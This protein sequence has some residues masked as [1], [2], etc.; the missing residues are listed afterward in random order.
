MRAT[1]TAGGPRRAPRRPSPARSLRLDTDPPAPGATE[2]DLAP[3]VSLGRYAECILESMTS[4]VL[5]V[6]T[7][8]RIT[9]I[10]KEA[11]LILCR[12]ADDLIGSSLMEHPGM[13]ELFLLIN[14]IR[15]TRPLYERS[16]EQYEVQLEAFDGRIVPLG[17][18]VNALLD[19]AQG[20]L[21]YVAICKDLSERK[22]LEATVER[23]ERLSALGTMASGVAHNFNN[24]LA[25]ILGRVQLMIRFPEKVDMQA[26]LQT[27]QKAALDGAATVKRIQDFA[28]TRVAGAD[29]A[30]V[31]IAE[32]AADIAEYARATA[33]KRGE[34]QGVEFHLEAR[35]DSARYVS[36]VAS[37]LREVLINL[38][39]NALD[40]MP[41][42][43]ALEFAVRDTDEGVELE[44]SDTGTGMPE[45]VRQKIFDP[46]FTTKGTQGMGLGLAESY[47][48]VKRHKG[49]FEVTSQPGKGTTFLV[50]LPRGLAKLSAE[51][52]QARAL[53]RKVEGRILVVD[54]EAEQAELLA[55]MLAGEGHRVDQANSGEEALERFE[56]AGDAYDLL[57][58]DVSMPG[59]EGW[60]LARRVREKHPDLGIVV[61]TG[62][63]ANFS[64][65]ELEASGVDRILSKPVR[66]DTFVDTVNEVL[67]QYQPVRG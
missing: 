19:E 16:S 11:A 9:L 52:A 42:G 57:V 13:M 5:V 27:I 64:D 58:T 3:L 35:P 60:E 54:D 14:R 66:L 12:D 41:E 51:E 30:P 47:G 48:I 56:A 63:A 37:E 46:F 36:G 67:V 38:V 55:E 50:V 17:V 40:A 61:V 15:S 34:E 28:R 53:E 26:G 33:Q 18:S 43:G 25:A 6:D 10:N 4:G 39:N 8:G 59:I 22:A 31:A 45:H 21:G 49:R 32:V 65:A 1:L 23:A 2:E 62:L 24:I 29:F 44:V 20:V 7:V